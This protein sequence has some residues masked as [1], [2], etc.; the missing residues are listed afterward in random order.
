MIAALPNS[1]EKAPEALPD[2]AI[3]C[4]GEWN[5]RESGSNAISRSLSMSI[6][7]FIKGSM[8]IWEGG[9]RD[10]GE[11]KDRGYKRKK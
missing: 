6:S 1:V 2:V 3:I 5:S 8:K 7:R 9:A 4:F 10:R 11:N